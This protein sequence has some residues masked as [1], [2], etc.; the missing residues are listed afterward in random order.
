MT[1]YVIKRPEVSSGLKRTYHKNLE[2]IE[3]KGRS[4]KEKPHIVI[5]QVCAIHK[6][7]PAKKAWIRKAIGTQSNSFYSPE[8]HTTPITALNARHGDLVFTTLEAAQVTKLI[9][10]ERLKKTY[11]AELAQLRELF[12]RNV[13]N[14]QE[15]MDQLL[16]EH[17]DLFI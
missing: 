5:E 13:P 14:V 8:L 7:S 17:P 1:V 12:K 2:V 11:E 15:P 6:Y 4:G 9:L 3:C 10:I 16:E